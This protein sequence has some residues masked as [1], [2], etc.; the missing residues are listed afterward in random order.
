LLSTLRALILDVSFRV[1]KD[2][3]PDSF[4]GDYRPT[5]CGRLREMV[6]VERVELIGNYK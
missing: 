1:Y 4:K 5:R 2:S 6:L 3:P